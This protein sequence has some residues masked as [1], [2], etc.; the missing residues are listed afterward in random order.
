MNAPHRQFNA[1][2]IERLA[3]SCQDV[4]IDAV[5]ERAIEIKQE[6]RFDTHAI[7]PVLEL[8]SVSTDGRVRAFAN[9]IAPVIDWLA[10]IGQVGEHEG[11][12]HWIRMLSAS[13]LPALTTSPTRFPNIDL[14]SGETCEIEPLRGERLRAGRTSSGGL[15]PRRQGP[16]DRLMLA[17]RRRL[18]WPFQ[19]H[20]RSAPSRLSDI[21]RMLGDRPRRHFFE[22]VGILDEGPAHRP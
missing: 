19:G 15:A 3:L 6:N 13:P 2:C 4:L 11:T 17:Q 10:S 14:A 8:R 16:R 22:I 7:P 20:V 5:N 12:G 21:V 1:L 9:L 18:R